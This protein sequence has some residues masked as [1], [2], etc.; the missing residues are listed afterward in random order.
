MVEPAIQCQLLV[1]HWS[2]D[3]LGTEF[4]G[5]MGSLDQVESLGLKS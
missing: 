3:D 5:V 4:P 1:H 2:V